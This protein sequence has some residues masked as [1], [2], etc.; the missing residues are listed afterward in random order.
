MSEWFW[1]IFTI[2]A[3]IGT[4]YNSSK[5]IKGFYFWI[6]ANIALLIQTLI[7][8]VYNLSI[9]YAIYL[10]YSIRGIYKWRIKNET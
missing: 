5:N 3:I 7:V 8:G 2:I 10:F 9:L 1:Y 6:V 4:H